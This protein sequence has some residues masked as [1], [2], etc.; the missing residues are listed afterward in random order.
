[1]LKSCQIPNV[2]NKK[3]KNDYK[4]FNKSKCKF[5][6]KVNKQKA[7]DCKFLLLSEKTTCLSINMLFFTF[8]TCVNDDSYMQKGLS[9]GSFIQEEVLDD[10]SYLQ[11]LNDQIGSK[12]SK[13]QL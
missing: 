13:I 5:I 2:K 10:Y 7:F 6:F 8:E 3:F 11:Y 12:P 1:M 4:I 9:T